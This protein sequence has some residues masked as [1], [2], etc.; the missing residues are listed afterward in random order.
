MKP[1][2]K[3]N[4]LTILGWNQATFGCP[5]TKH[6]AFR[7]DAELTELLLAIYF[8]LPPEKIFEELADVAIMTWAVAAAMQID[9]RPVIR[10]N[11]RLPSERV[12]ALVLASRLR[13]RYGVFLQNYSGRT[14]P[15][16][17]EIQRPFALALQW[18][19]MLIEYYNVDIAS[20]VDAKMAINR[21]RNWNNTGGGN[22]QHVA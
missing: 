21:K 16:Y 14:S 8:D 6:I 15:G 17:K 18:L 10:E 11:M 5:S 12:S 19:E 9:A 7:T 3:E 1:F 2:G 4:P 20:I 13:A 22:Y